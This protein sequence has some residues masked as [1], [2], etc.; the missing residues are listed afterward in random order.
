MSERHAAWE[1]VAR[2]LAHEI[3]NPLTPIQLSIDSL[4]EKYLDKIGEDSEKF[5]NYLNTIN[6][7]IKDIENL[8]NEFSD[9]ARMPKPV[10]KKIDVIAIAFRTLKLYE[11]ADPNIKF[12]LSKTKNNFN[13]KADEEQLNR[14]FLNLIKNSVESIKEKRNKNVDFKG[15]INV[16][17]RPN[18]DYIYITI[19]DNGVGFSTINKTKMFTPYFTTKKEGTGLGLAIVGK[20]I[21]DHNGEI[22]L[23]S[24]YDGAMVEIKIPN[25]Y[26]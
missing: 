1:N 18:S 26:G 23:N 24:E 21:N 12:I 3:K 9:F 25:W 20:I 10:F 8:V 13:I 19:I 4:R 11:L 15:K 14:V 2:K 6:K 22:L 17:I 7:Q 16:D 5:I